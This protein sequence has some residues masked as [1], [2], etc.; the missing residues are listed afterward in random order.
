MLSS[1]IYNLPPREYWSIEK[2]WNSTE[3]C[4]I[5]IP[6][7]R[8]VAKGKGH[9]NVGFVLKYDRLFIGFSGTA[10]SEY[11]LYNLNTSITNF[12]IAGVP[13]KAHE[14]FFTMAQEVFDIIK[15]YPVL[16]RAV[17]T[18]KHIHT[19]GHS[20][21]GPVGCLTG[22]LLAEAF[23]K[24]YD[25][26]TAIDFGSPRFWDRSQFY[27]FPTKRLYFRGVY[28]LVTCVP[29]RWRGPL[30]AFVH[31]GKAQWVYPSG[32]IKNNPPWYRVFYL[33]YLYVVAAM[34]LSS[35]STAMKHHSVNHYVSAILQNNFLSRDAYQPDSDI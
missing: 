15:K 19:V 34:S 14:G 20:A 5:S 22:M 29:F 11:W 21:G 24:P 17:R 27:D 3:C 23:E 8:N 7:K 1:G 18:A 2:L 35:V 13:Y 30:N 26:F 31:V 16:R 25:V 9:I 10:D 6:L 32:K 4:W 12:T 33:W 28:D